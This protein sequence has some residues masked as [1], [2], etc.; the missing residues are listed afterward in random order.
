MLVQ[1]TDSRDLHEWRNP[2]WVVSVRNGL[3][4]RTQM[5]TISL[6]RSIVFAFVIFALQAP[7]ASQSAAEVNF[8][9]ARNSVGP[10]EFYEL[11]AFGEWTVFCLRDAAAEDYCEATQW[12]ADHPAG[13]QLEF[14]LTPLI[15]FTE[16]VDV[17][18]DV[19]PRALISVG[20][21]SEAPRYSNLVASVV[22]LDGEAFDGYSCKV[23]DTEVCT[24]G[25]D[26]DLSNIRRMLSAETAMVTVT[27]AVT[28]EA[29]TEIEVSLDGLAQ[30]YAR[31][32]AFNAEI[33][34]IDLSDTRNL[35]EMCNFVDAS[36]QRSISF[37]IDEDA[38]FSKP[39]R[40]ENWLGTRGSGTCPSYVI[41]AY[42]T[43]DLTTA[44]RAEFCLVFDRDADEYKGVALGATD[45]YRICRTPA[46]TLCERVNNSRDAALA[47]VAAATTITAG[48]TAAT[49]TLCV[50][51]V[52]HSSG[53]YILTGSAGYLSGTIGP[54]AGTLAALT[55]PFALTAAAVSVV[56]V[57]GAVYVCA[58]DTETVTTE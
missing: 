28:H 38:P 47:T 42:Y 57:G 18:V 44:Q 48:T 43:P 11:D 26:I 30:A 52:T 36:R 58:E 7:F 49:T 19:A 10:S 17:T 46:T 53:L 22:S 21:I 34:G 5:P 24:Q 39:S 3:Q 8:P 41:L 27:D 33:F 56:A 16:P 29:V 55:G 12:I 45:N 54:L 20:T 50:T 13:V 25:P 6:S 51:A 35:G 31:A 40:Q 32:N 9:D 4:Q 14:N 1:Q 2:T 37:L 23:K 15:D